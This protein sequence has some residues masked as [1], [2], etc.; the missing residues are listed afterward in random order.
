MQNLVA[1]SHTL[2][3]HVRGPKMWRTQGHRPNRTGSVD[4][5]RNTLQLHICYHC[6]FGRSRSNRLGV[7]R[8]PPKWESWSPTSLGWWAW[9]TPRNTLL[10]LYATIPILVAV[11]QTIW[12]SSKGF[13]RILGMLRPSSLGMGACLTLETRFCLYVNVN[14]NRTFIWSRVMQHLY[15]AV[16]AE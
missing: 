12:A 11:G 3:A 1:V 13:Q 9:L 10:P 2:C 5:P 14:V 8:N 16:C 6:K 15:C 7:G 4:D